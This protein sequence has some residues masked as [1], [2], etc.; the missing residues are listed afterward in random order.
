MFKRSLMV[1]IAFVACVV[2]AMTYPVRSISTWIDPVSGSVK[3]ETSW[4]FIPTR[5]R[6]ETSELER[7]IVA[8]EG[9]HNPQW[10]F[11]NENYRL[12]SG[13]FAGCGVGRTPKIF[14]IHAGDS[15]TR[16][17]HVATDA[18][19]VEFV[20]AMRSGT[21]DEQERAVDEA[22]KILERGYGSPTAAPAGPS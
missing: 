20:R 17:V 3:F 5:T 9:C 21:P 10:H 13:R 18:E 16:F 6:I 19:I 7:W 15:N 12:I 2:L 11:L 14:P 4:L 8:H 22:G 1:L